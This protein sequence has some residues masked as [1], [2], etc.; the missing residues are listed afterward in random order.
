MNTSITEGPYL[1]REISTSIKVGVRKGADPDSAYASEVFNMEDTSEPMEDTL[2][3]FRVLEPRLCVFW[4]L[5]ILGKDSRKRQLAAIDRSLHTAVTLLSDSLPD[6]KMT[7][8]AAVSTRSDNN[9]RPFSECD[10]SDVDRYSLALLLCS[11][12]NHNSVRWAST[13]SIAIRLA[14]VDTPLCLLFDLFDSTR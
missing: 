12:V 5:V 9:T 1:G 8:E 2:S 13:M 3:T 10:K 4:S 11:S 14:P 7:V 6:D